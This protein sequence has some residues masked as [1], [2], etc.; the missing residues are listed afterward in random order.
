[1]TKAPREK[2]QGKVKIIIPLEYEGMVEDISHLS[3]DGDNP[4]TMTK[5]QHDATWG[6]LQAFGWVYPLVTDKDGKFSD[7]EQRQYVALAHGEN[8]APVLRLN[9]TDDNRRL[10]RQV[11]NKLKGSHDPQK[12]ALEYKR[13]QDA[14]RIEDLKNL[15][16]VEQD[17]IDAKLK[18]LRE[19]ENDGK[20]KMEKDTVE[21]EKK[22]AECPKCGYRFDPESHMV[23][24]TPLETEAGDLDKYVTEGVD[25]GL[26]KENT[27]LLNIA[28]NTVQPEVTEK[29]IAVTEAFGIGIDETRT[30]KVFEGFKLS[31]N[32][33]D[34]IYVTG[35]SGSGKTT[36]LKALGKHEVDRGRK[37]IDFDT[38]EPGQH[39][40]VIDSIHPDINRTMDVLS[41]VGLSEAFIMLRRFD[42][43]SDGQKYRFKLAKMFSQDA[44]CYLI[45]KIGENLDRVMAKVLVYNLQKF[46]RR[47]RKMIIAASTH[48]DIIE[49]FNPNIMI[50]K[51]FAEKAQLRY[52]PASPREF[53]LIKDMKIEKATS[54]DYEELEQ[55]HYL[56]S[57]PGYTQDRFKLTYKDRTI[58]VVVYVAPFL[59]S[60]LRTKAMPQYPIIS[61]KESAALINRDI[62][63]LARIIINPKFRGVG[64]A[65]KLTKETMPLTEKRVVETIAAMAQYNPFFE[66]AG[67]TKMGKM[68]L[69]REQ[70][71]VV[72]TVK[73]L[74]ENIVIL[75]SPKRRK[76]FLEGLDDKQ[77]RELSSA[78]IKNMRNL[79]KQSSSEGSGAS[80]VETMIKE[81]M[82]NGLESLLK[83]LIPT[84]RVYLYWINEKIGDATP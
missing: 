23:I 17:E 80:R 30:F 69:T 26:G 29:V 52:Y 42:E 8:Y 25:E 18:L 73:R 27:V 11:L 24:S 61:S 71:A 1:M 70:K 44:D 37:V 83:N 67:M 81:S 36:F 14:G 75:N 22:M 77:T 46:A 63:R 84:E 19:D 39:E 65:V 2:W 13:L 20:R 53:S 68:P 28:F 48:H 32:D 6:S 57:S 4:N 51:E 10:L 38:I 21:P 45:D 12:D 41:S 50:Y 43:L 31:Y 5:A 62:T 82:G 54:Q 66:K 49:D 76:A 59:T 3:K 56:D 72:D 64:L 58:G 9:L 34:L 47:S 40:V 78:L 55:F 35:D 79:I 7:G 74:G 60:G 16:A 15:I 33:G